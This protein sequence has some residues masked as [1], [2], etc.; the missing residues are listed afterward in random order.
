MIGGD[1]FIQKH[2]IRYYNHLLVFRFYWGFYISGWY[3]GFFKKVNIHHRY[4]RVHVH[5]EVFP[6]YQR[7]Y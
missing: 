1:E 6:Y 4:K 2:R 7:V 5:A 3:K